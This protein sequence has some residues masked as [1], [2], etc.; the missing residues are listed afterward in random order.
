LGDLKISEN[1]V[2]RVYIETI[3]SRNAATGL[4]PTCTIIDE[5]G[6]RSAGTVAEMGNGWYKVTDFTPDAAGCWCTEWKLGTPLIYTIYHAFKEFK[7]GG[8]QLDDINTALTFQHQPISVFSQAA[9]VQNTWYTVLDTT[10]N[11]KIYSIRYGVATTQETLGLELTIDG[12]V[13][14]DEFVT[15]ADTAKYLALNN[16]YQGYLTN[17]VDL[18]APIGMPVYGSF[19]LECRSFKMR[20]RKTTLAGNGAFVGR[21]VY[22]KR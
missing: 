11:V 4:T 9:P 1:F 21:I 8:G 19:P 2:D 3:S 7:V 20:I 6:T 15:P 22:A 16:Y 10:L 18:S 14:T 17:A 5:V 13:W 12:V